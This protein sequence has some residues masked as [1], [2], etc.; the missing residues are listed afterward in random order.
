MKIL[1]ETESIEQIIKFIESKKSSEELYIDFYRRN[2]VIS[3]YKRINNVE[4]TIS[5]ELN[6]QSEIFRID[7]SNLF[8]KAKKQYLKLNPKSKITD[9]EIYLDENYA[10]IDGL[11]ISLSDGIDLNTIIGVYNEAGEFYSSVFLEK[12][13]KKDLFIENKEKEV[14]D[15]WLDQDVKEKNE[16]LTKDISI[17]ISK[18]N[19]EMTLKMLKNFFIDCDKDIIQSNDIIPLLKIND[20]T[21]YI[22][23][24]LNT[25]T[26]LNY[27]SF[28]KG[29]TIPKNETG[30]I[31]LYNFSNLY[32]TCL[33]KDIENHIKGKNYYFLK[34][35]RKSI[36][37][38]SIEIN[39]EYYNRLFETNYKLFIDYNNKIF[40]Y[41]NE[42]LIWQ[43]T[44]S[45]G[46]AIPEI[47]L[48]FIE[49]DVK[50][51]L[52]KKICRKSLSDI[53]N[54]IKNNISNKSIQI[55]IPIN[56]EIFAN[57]DDKTIQIIIEYENNEL[58]CLYN[59]NNLLQVNSEVDSWIS[60]IVLSNIFSESNRKHVKRL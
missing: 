40:L 3:D 5:N 53:C 42:K 13:S 27:E 59:K 16:F 46:E 29:Y 4:L 32:L 6:L 7:F 49:N 55:K 31:Y 8:E 34:T 15:L 37:T 19:E 56:K 41:S 22:K 38:I 10:T 47:L 17:P 60:S 14:L 30:I 2:K 45:N 33:N 25:N 52:M 44:Y 9:L 11:S 35:C 28:K 58:V 23:T 50:N 39:N 57:K 20:E 1:D 36:N 21:S 24:L 12:Y 18:I 54:E 51:N 48:S 26:L 43:A